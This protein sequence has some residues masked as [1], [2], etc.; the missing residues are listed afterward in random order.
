[1]TNNIY[2][3]AALLLI[4]QNG[5]TTTLD[6]K[7]YIRTTLPG[8]YCVQSDVSRA[9][10]DAE[11]A[12]ELSFQDLGTHR[13]YSAVNKNQTITALEMGN[14]I[15]DNVGKTVYVE[16]KEKKNN[17][18]RQMTC[19]ITSVDILGRAYVEENGST[20]SFYLNRV[21]LLKVGNITYVRK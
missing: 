4:A 18:L 19:T 12:G 5:S 15:I 3:A 7:N 1:M 14:H 20:K 9:L 8:F 2:L 16:F 13:V 21:K 6:V 10:Q 11:E 17:S